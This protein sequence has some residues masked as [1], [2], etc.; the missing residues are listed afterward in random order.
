MSDQDSFKV[1]DKRGQTQEDA[2]NKVDAKEEATSE[3]TPKEPREMKPEDLPEAN[4]VHFA[5]SLGTSCMM[6]LGLMENPNTNSKEKD[7][8]MAKH[9]IDL[10]TMLE[11]KTQGNLSQDEQTF[12][13]QL[14]YELRMHYV[15]ASK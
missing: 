10:L 8:L 3:P 5:A 6:H 13:T 14:L 2:S 7:L 4:F 1:N 12:L 9:E 11:T 15:Q